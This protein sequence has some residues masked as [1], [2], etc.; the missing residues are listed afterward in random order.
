MI[1]APKISGPEATVCDMKALHLA[2]RRSDRVHYIGAGSA[3]CRITKHMATPRDNEI[4]G[5]VT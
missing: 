4:S 3:R 5:G 1:P 2:H